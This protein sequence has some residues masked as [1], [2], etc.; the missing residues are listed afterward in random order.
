MWQKQYEKW[1]NYPDLDE[2]L[3]AELEA[4]S[5]AEIE[6]A[7]YRDLEFGTAGMRGIMGPGCNR[8]N[9][10]MIRKVN[11]G[12]AQY[13]ESKGKEA[14]EKG[15]A[16]AYDN[17]HNSYEFA[18]ESAKILAS[19]DINVYIFS[20]LRPTPELSFTVRD[21][22]CFGGIV[23]TASH[24]P[25]EYNGYKL[26]DEK[27]CQ[28]VPHL[29]K[30][31][32]E[33]INNIEDELALEINLSPQQ[34]QRIKYIDKEMDDKYLNTIKTIQFHPEAVKDIK[35]VFT[36]QHG[37]SRINMC[38]LFEETGYDYVLVKEQADPDP[39]F[40]NTLVPNPEDPKAY[41]LA[42]EYARKYDA[43]IVL[44]TD[45][46][47]DRMGVQVKH[48]G[49][50]IFLSGNQTG[51]VIIE[52]L[53]R[54]LKEKKELPKNGVM[55][56]TVVTNDLG[57]VIAED[58]GLKVVLGLTGFKFIG[59]KIAKYCDEQGL[60]FVFGYE[61]SYGSIVQDFVR[62]K[63]SLQAC[64]ILAEAA[65]YY[66][67][68]GQTLF[69]VVEELYDRYGYHYDMQEN[70]MLPGAD[71]L[72]RL[73]QILSNLRK[74]EP[75]TLG[76]LEVVKIEDYGTLI[77][78]TKNHEEKIEDFVVSDVLKYFLADGSWVAIRPSGTE[79]KCKF[80]YCILGRDKEECQKTTAA[81]KAEI[82]EII[83]GS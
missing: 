7:F 34:E 3:K 14:K 30:P 55:I 38:R 54:N 27:G 76:G 45:P 2:G 62:D 9:I 72:Q 49:D 79:P 23:C 82:D 16:I 13:I 57:N 69:D 36:P 1:L 77:R 48:Q 12:F 5:Q 26:Y 25:K 43:D 11:T 78:K 21:L 73:Q 71:G 83:A 61:E 51:A 81:I 35:I 65:N 22:N 70:I 33:N 39:N 63:D 15:I 47:A 46:D 4:M 17:R 44:S 60:K 66:K 20:S 8:M 74:D 40:S 42:L 29:I 58:Y 64:L 19:F 18:K 80:Y 28:L 31:I 53:C 56:S 32:I 67:Q 75:K 24:N 59:E 6:D 68:K 52:Y 10:Y 41:I 50:Y 37:T